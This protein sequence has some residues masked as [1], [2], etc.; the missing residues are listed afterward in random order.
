MTIKPSLLEKAYAYFAPV[1]ALER[2]RA[3]FALA[4]GYTGA[5]RQRQSLAQW[6]AGG[7]DADADLLP[8]LATLRERS[9]DLVRN[10]PLASGVINTVCTSVIGTGLRLQVRIDRDFLKLSDTAAE[11]FA[12][13]A[14]R[15]FALW[16][17]STDCD[18]GRQLTFYDYQALVF[19][20]GLENGDCFVLLPYVERPGDPYSLR[21]QLIEADRVCNPDYAVDSDALAGGVQKDGYGAPLA[22]HILDK[23]PG[24]AQGDNKIWR[25]FSARGPSDRRRILHVYT[26]LRP[27]QSRGVP[28]LAPVIEAFKQLG[29][30]THAE[31]TAALVSAKFTVFVK[32]QDGDT[33]FASSER[34]HRHR[35]QDYRLG[36]GSIVSLAEGEEISTANPGRP[37]AAFDPFVQSILRQIGVALELPYE[38]LIKHFTASYSAARAASLE[39]LKFYNTK[40]AFLATHFCQPVYEEWLT[41]AIAEG[42]L[43]APGYFSGDPS[44]RKAY[45]GTVWIGPAPGQIDPLKEINAAEKR[46]ELGVSSLARETAALTGMDWEVEFQQQR[47]EARLRESLLKQ[48][49]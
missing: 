25:A 33:S 41:H 49:P 1:Q 47:K 46:I 10:N 9:R 2:Q 40:R 7:N 30:Y 39:A 23:H 8:D 6:Q 14:E 44:V 22:Y 3:Q 45:T 12:A 31:V 34:G 4:G 18:L 43:H 29:M 28:Y 24:G 26:L 38:V 15:E 37:N 21:L 32:T 36:S 20:S 35:G 17:E 42:R 27:N 19:R 13:Q 11:A 16:A 5:S 48:D